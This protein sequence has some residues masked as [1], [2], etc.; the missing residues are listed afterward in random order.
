VQPAHPHTTPPPKYPAIGLQGRVAD[1]LDA[2]CRPDADGFTESVPP[3]DGDRWSWSALVQMVTDRLGPYA[4]ADADSVYGPVARYVMAEA[5]S[6]WVTVGYGPMTRHALIVAEQAG[7]TARCV[8]PYAV[9]LWLSD[10]V[11]V[12]TARQAD[13]WNG[14]GRFRVG[15]V[16]ATQDR[17]TYPDGRTAYVDVGRGEMRGVRPANSNRVAFRM[18]TQDDFAERFGNR[19]VMLD[20]SVRVYPFGALP[21]WAIASPELCRHDDCALCTERLKHWHEYSLT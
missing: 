14:D 16:T 15:A 10:A 13:Y 17:I 3:D 21:D 11:H 19:V 2:L 4:G 12:R 18:H 20:G 9:T 5:A 7:V 8:A 1:A 6:D